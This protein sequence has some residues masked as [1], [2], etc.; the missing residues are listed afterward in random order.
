MSTANASS[1]TIRIVEAIASANESDPLD[2]GPLYEV[3]DLDALEALHAN[4]TCEWRVEFS[5]ENN[6]VI[7]DNQN[8]HVRDHST[9]QTLDQ[10]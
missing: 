5:T 9:E 4:S 10:R 3:I 1:L 6:R 8:V 7:I 2:V